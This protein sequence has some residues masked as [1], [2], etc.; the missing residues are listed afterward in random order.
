MVN[1]I[2]EMVKGIF[3][4]MIIGYEFAGPFLARCREDLG[5][6]QKEFANM[7][8]WSLRKQKLLEKPRKEM[9]HCSAFNRDAIVAVLTTLHIQKS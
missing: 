2:D 9:R 5:V 6:T 3:G 7:C 8:G 4:K 1:K